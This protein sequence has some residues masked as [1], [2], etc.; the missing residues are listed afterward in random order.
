[1]TH[2]RSSG[3]GEH[4]M[5]TEPRK[6]NILLKL[7]AEG[8]VP[9][10]GGCA[11]AL[12][13]GAVG[14]L[15]VIV[16]AQSVEKAINLFGRGIVEKWRDWFARANPDERV[17]AVAE[18]AALPPDAAREEAQEAL[19]EF[20]PDVDPQDLAIALDYLSSLPHA[21]SRALVRDPSGRTSLPST[22]TWDDAPSLLQ[23]L[24]QD[25]APYA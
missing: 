19:A 21:L 20:A 18:L 5:P 12:I 16:V 25:I 15:A 6:R 7:A 13:A 9:V 4:F 23:L 8:V 1:M 3:P 2:V 10:I 17:A 14:G 22:V 11:G 24:P